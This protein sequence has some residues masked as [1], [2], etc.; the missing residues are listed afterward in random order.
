MIYSHT[1][2]N[3][4]RKE[5]DKNL[6]LIE[7]FPIDLSIVNIVFI[8]RKIINDPENKINY[9][10]MLEDILERGYSYEIN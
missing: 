2:Y 5:R 8:V 9:L 7:K 4:I 1:T 6:S 10:E 3:V